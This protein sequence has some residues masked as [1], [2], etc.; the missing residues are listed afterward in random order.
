MLQ[1]YALSFCYPKGKQ[2]SLS[3]PFFSSYVAQCLPLLA[4]SWSPIPIQFG[5][6]CGFGSPLFCF[7]IALESYC[8]TPQRSFPSHPNLSLP[9]HPNQ[10]IL[11]LGC[12]LF[13]FS[14]W[15][16]KG[17]N[18]QFHTLLN[19]THILIKQV[20]NVISVKI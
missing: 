14:S 13:F 7:G 5:T 8:R 2:P 10:G 19:D 20:G 18:K 16:H 17:G 11:R 1:P 3:A 15:L 4:T 9:V 12:L 6:E